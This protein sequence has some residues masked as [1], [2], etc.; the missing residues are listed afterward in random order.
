LKYDAERHP[1]WRLDVVFIALFSD[2]GIHP[3]NDEGKK[4]PRPPGR[5]AS[6]HA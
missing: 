2:F 6:M 3:V 4:T 5:I 1:A